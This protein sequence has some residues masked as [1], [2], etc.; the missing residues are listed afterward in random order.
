MYASQTYVL[1]FEVFEQLQLSVCSLRQDRRAEWLHD[2][3][4]RH[5]LPSELVLCRTMPNMSVCPLSCLH[6]L[7][8]PYEPK[9]SHAH[10]LQVSVAVA[11]SVELSIATRGAAHANA[12][13]PRIPA[14]DLEGR[15]KDLGTDELGHVD[16]V[17]RCVARATQTRWWMVRG[18]AEEGA[19]DTRFSAAGCLGFGLCAGPLSLVGYRSLARSP[20]ACTRTVGLPVSNLALCYCRLKRS[21]LQSQSRPAKANAYDCCLFGPQ[22]SGLPTCRAG[23]SGGHAQISLALGGRREYYDDRAPIGQG[24]VWLLAQRSF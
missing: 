5:S 21:E 18:D 14:G 15:A 9:G 10:G 4:H 7:D 16:G 22:G 17:R 24:K 11:A 12:W 19:V 13:F 20:R 1:V 2:L 3:L 23:A 6:D 8:V